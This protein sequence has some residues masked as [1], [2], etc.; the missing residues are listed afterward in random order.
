VAV[1]SRPEVHGFTGGGFGEN[2]YVVSCSG[3]AKAI[4]VDPGAAVEAMLD[5]VRRA[6]LDIVA[7]VLT[8]AHLD[9]IEGVARAHEV[10][11]AAVHLHPDDEILYRQA[12]HQAQLFGV[13]IDT[14][15]P[16]DEYL[17]QGE[18][19]RVGDCQFEVRSTPGHSPGHI[20]LVGSGVA[21]VGD[22]VFGGSIGRTDLPGGD[23]Q[24]L[25]ASIRGEIL[26]LPDE[27]ILYSGHGPETTVGRERRSNPFLTPHLG[28]SNFA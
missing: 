8:H 7:I 5:H 26:S 20:I 1:N 9:H 4:L 13:R 17:R 21:I 6:S 16:I 25:M 11:G 27:T 23:F 14:P 28:G 3:T 15:P 22:C 18:L 2:C 19:V 10:T 24:T 12:P